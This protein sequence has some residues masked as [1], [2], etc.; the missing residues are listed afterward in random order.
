MTASSLQPGRLPAGRGA[1]AAPAQGDPDLRAVR[2]TAVILCLLGAVALIWVFYPYLAV[3][4]AATALA[5]ALQLPVLVLGGRAV[6]VGPAHPAPVPGVVGGRG[7]LGGDRGD[8]RRAA[9]Q[10]G[11]DRPAGQVRGGRVGVTL[12]CGGGGAVSRSR[13]RRP[14]SR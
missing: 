9:G 3:F 8:G 12:V 13:R 6:P 1:R 14:G 4:P 7:D 5:V 2:V 10:P 11:P